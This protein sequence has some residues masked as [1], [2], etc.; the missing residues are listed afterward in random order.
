VETWDRDA[1]G[2][3][4]WACVFKHAILLRDGPTARKGR[5]GSPTA[6]VKD[7]RSGQLRGLGG[8]GPP[9]KSETEVT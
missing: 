2:V 7:V 1:P 8:A 5:K 4:C 3:E 9:D 6:K